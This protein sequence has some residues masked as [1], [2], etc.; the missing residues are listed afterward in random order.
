MTK[1]V[2]RAWLVL[3]AFGLVLLIA[4]VAVA[5]RLVGGVTRPIRELAQ[6]SHR[7]AA[8]ELD[9]RAPLDGPTEVREVARGLNHLAGRI[10][11]LIWQERESVADLSHRL[12]TPLT[13]LRL[14]AEA[15][16]E[17]GGDGGT[18]HRRPVPGD[19]RSALAARRRPGSGRG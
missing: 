13:A 15:V 12:R 5:D 9:A 1:G 10:R 4:G 11:D 14:E 7:L 19:R 3:A 8:G 18:A 6:V 16:A 2:A 17:S